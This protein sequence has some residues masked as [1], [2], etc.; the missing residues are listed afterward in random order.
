MRKFL[1]NYQDYNI[2]SH[3]IPVT[4]LIVSARSNGRSTFG[5]KVHGSV[6][7]TQ[8]SMRESTN[9]INRPYMIIKV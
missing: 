2:N 4:D 1:S 9:A 3:V 5:V 6:P 7:F 8:I